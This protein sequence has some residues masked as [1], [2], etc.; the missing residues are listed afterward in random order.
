MAQKQSLSNREKS[1]K[2]KSITNQCIMT[3]ITSPTYNTHPERHQSASQICRSITNHLKINNRPIRKSHR[4]NG[5]KALGFRLGRPRFP[6][7][8]RSA[9]SPKNER[10]L[11]P[12]FVA[13]PPS[14]TWLP[15]PPKVAPTKPTPIP[16]L[17]PHARPRESST[18]ADSHTV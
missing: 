16:A 4:H 1:K 13:H 2:R 11:F 14:T 15:V 6:K 12:K 7:R 17:M 5:Q 18:T 3:K 10:Q 8:A 9:S